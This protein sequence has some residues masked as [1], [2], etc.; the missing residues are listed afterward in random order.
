MNVLRFING[1]IAAAIASG[2]DKKTE[3]N[4]LVYDLGGGTL[5]VSL[6]TI[7]TGSFDLKRLIGGRCKDSTVLKNIELAAVPD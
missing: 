4:V 6:L 3:E 7:D 2:L 5:E 1:P